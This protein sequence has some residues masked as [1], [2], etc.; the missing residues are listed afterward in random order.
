MGLRGVMLRGRA[1]VNGFPG[2][3]NVLVSQIAARLLEGRSSALPA[4]VA[5][6]FGRNYNA[7]LDLLSAAVPS[8]WNTRGYFQHNAKGAADFCVLLESGGSVVVRGADLSMHL[9]TVVH[10]T[11]EVPNETTR[12]FYKRQGYVPLAA[13]RHPLDMNLSFALKLYI[14]PPP[15]M[16]Q[17][18]A[19][20]GMSARDFA[21]RNKIADHR[22]LGATSDLV[23]KFYD[24]VPRDA[25]KYEDVLAD[26]K[27]AVR[28]IAGRLGIGADDPGPI[29]AI[30]GTKE[31]EPGHFN[32][33]G[34][35]KWRRFFS[36]R[37]L[38]GVPEGL[39][40][41]FARFSATSGQK[42]VKQTKSRLCPRRT[43]STVFALLGTFDHETLGE[44]YDVSLVAA[45]VGRHLI[46]ASDAILAD[47]FAQR[48]AAKAH[49][50]LWQR[51]AIFRGA[52]LWNYR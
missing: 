10:A 20:S 39:W 46:V 6:E 5:S 26:P 51:L 32:K 29:A 37:D 49:L 31:F 25:F 2:A 36:R 45:R 44:H 34:T 7:Q 12:A 28:D 18:A 17:L 14:K 33:P 35:G 42:I 22:W 21:A 24:N 38:A 43:Q 27:R 41:T 13:V 16:E 4:D 48:L 30:V 50:P 23:A 9:N 47:E 3:G 40:K 52:R 15:N 19:A 11:H 8:H 1:F